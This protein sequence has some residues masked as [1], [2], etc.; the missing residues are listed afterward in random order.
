MNK[1]PAPIP[2]DFA[3]KLEVVLKEERPPALPSIGAPGSPGR[4]FMTRIDSA[5]DLAR[6]LAGSMQELGNYDC[7]ETA[8]FVRSIEAQ[9]KAWAV[10]LIRRK[11]RNLADLE[12]IVGDLNPSGDKHDER[13]KS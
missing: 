9:V 12:K 10:E 6:S 4:D 13:T 5:L 3:D 11:R 8:A 2:R 7:E 1:T